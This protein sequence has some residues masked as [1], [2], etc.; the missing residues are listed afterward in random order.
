MLERAEKSAG[1]SP[2][3]H[4]EIDRGF[5]LVG[6]FKVT[7]ATTTGRAKEEALPTYRRAA[8]VARVVAKS[9]EQWA[10]EELR[11]LLDQLLRL[12]MTV[13]SGD[14]ELSQAGSPGSEP[15]TAKAPPG[16]TRG[17]GPDRL[18]RPKQ[19][20]GPTGPVQVEAVD[21]ERQ[22]QLRSSVQ[23]ATRLAESLR[24][25]LREMGSQPGAD[26]EVILTQA[27]AFLGRARDEVEA[28]QLDEAAATLMTV[29]TLHLRL[30]RALGR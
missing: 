23:T 19:P 1:P 17:D 4:K 22:N 3:V 6:N 9:D 12:A 15:T 25:G 18:K 8:E 30:R 11:Q 5:V 26:S 16:T 21:V 2:S 14:F 13:S 7:V 20:G 27:E 29:S 24:T 28:G 10:R